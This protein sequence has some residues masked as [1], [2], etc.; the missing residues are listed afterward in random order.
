MYFVARYI[1]YMLL[2]GPFLCKSDF[3]S[4]TSGCL[5]YRANVIAFCFVSLQVGHTV[6]GHVGQHVHRGPPA[7]PPFVPFEPAA[8]PATPL[9]PNVPVLCGLLLLL[10]A[11]ISGTACIQFIVSGIYLCLDFWLQFAFLFLS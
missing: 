8:P 1:S 2:R 10:L 11:C 6:A 5:L 4:A 7:R 9:R 3:K